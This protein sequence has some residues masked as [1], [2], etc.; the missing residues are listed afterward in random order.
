[1][2][3]ALEA[4]AATGGGVVLGGAVLDEQQVRLAPSPRCP[5]RSA[6]APP[7]CALRGRPVVTGHSRR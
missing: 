4:N 5:P 2:M 7:S 1:M 3:G 6:P